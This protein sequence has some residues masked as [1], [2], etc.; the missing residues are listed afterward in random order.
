M[1]RQLCLFFESMAFLLVAPIIIL[2]AVL[3]AVIRMDGVNG[4]P[5]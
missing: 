3:V 5:P 1:Q 4:T 2:L